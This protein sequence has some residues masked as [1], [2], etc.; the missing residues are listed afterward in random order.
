MMLMIS[1]IIIMI[2]THQVEPKM[3]SRSV[4]RQGVIPHSQL[5]NNLDNPPITAS[6]NLLFSSYKYK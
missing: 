4:D 1:I 5:I 2:I 6:C 3:V